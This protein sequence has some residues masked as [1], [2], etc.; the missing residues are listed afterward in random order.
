MEKTC[1]NCRLINSE[2]AQRCDCGY[3]FVS[4]S[5]EGADAQR[6]APQEL[7]ALPRAWIGYL[8][9]ATFLVA[10]IVE[11]VLDPTAADEPSLS[12]IAIGLAGWAYWFFCVYRIHVVLRAATDGRHPIT[13]GAAVGF[14]FIP[15]YN[16]Y[17][18]FKWPNAIADFIGARRPGKG[19]PGVVG[20]FLLCGSLLGRLDGALGL[21]VIFSTGLYITRSIDAALRP[22][23]AADQKRGPWMYAA[24][25]CGSLVVL[26]A[27][28]LIILGSFV[29]ETA[30]IPGRQLKAEYASVVEELGLLDPDEKI[31]FWYSDGLFSVKEGFY[32]FTNKKVVVYRQDYEEPA[33]IVTYSE[34]EDIEITRNLSFFEDSEI[35]LILADGVVFFPVS[36]DNDGDLRFVDLLIKKWQ[37]RRPL[38][39]GQSGGSRTWRQAAAAGG[40]SS[41]ANRDNSPTNRDK[42][43]AEQGRFPHER[44]SPDPEPQLQ[45]ANPGVVGQRPGVGVVARAH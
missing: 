30:V 40:L 16:L 39:Q 43:G 4:G 11:V 12:L 10:E 18:L 13:P 8:F 32:F 37:E 33:V 14:H 20:F 38:R 23:S 36:S 2:F 27:T 1:P 34:I 24:I 31:L 41:P 35:T 29:P 42:K 19:V 26:V 7:P 25:G 44:G 17:W 21:V 9:A 5:L 15:F 6:L 28:L 45:T 3:D 22:G